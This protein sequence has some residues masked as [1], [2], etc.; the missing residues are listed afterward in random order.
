[1]YRTSLRISTP[2]PLIL[3]I[4]VREVLVHY[5]FGFDLLDYIQGLLCLDGNIFLFVFL[6]FEVK[7]YDFIDE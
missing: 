3:S 7:T 6:A 1:M 5:Q 2:M 4:Q